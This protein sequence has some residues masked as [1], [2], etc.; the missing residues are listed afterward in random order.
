MAIF[1]KKD[2][3]KGKMAKSSSAAPKAEVKVMKSK[4]T[5]TPKAS[6][7]TGSRFGIEKIGQ[8]IK[9]QGEMKKSMSPLK[10]KGSSTKPKLVKTLTRSV[11]E[12]PTKRVPV[13][14]LT[15]SE[16][17]VSTPKMQ[18]TPWILKQTT[19][20]DSIP[21]LEGKSKQYKDS[22]IKATYKKGGYFTD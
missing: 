9:A 3:G 4:L 15:R 12:V 5:A 13:S 16:K 20:V 11:K 2:G 21:N 7:S 14:K 17:T 22:V 10:P 8:T 19:G 6:S 18:K 1:K